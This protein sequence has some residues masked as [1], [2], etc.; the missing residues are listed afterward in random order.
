MTRCLWQKEHS[1]AWVLVDTAWTPRSILPPNKNHR[2]S[3]GNFTSLENE[4]I[5]HLNYLQNAREALAVQVTEA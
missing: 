1:R 3:V 4:R 5:S 2:G